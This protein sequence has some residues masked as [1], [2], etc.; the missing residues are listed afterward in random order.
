MPLERAANG[1][2]QE[3]AKYEDDYRILG[4]VTARQQAVSAALPIKVWD[5]SQHGKHPWW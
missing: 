4:F 5:P 1:W 2:Q 3:L